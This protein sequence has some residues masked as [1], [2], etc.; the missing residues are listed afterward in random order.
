M[1]LLIN[2][3][4]VICIVLLSKT[5][6]AS[7]VST[8]DEL[9]SIYDTERCNQCHDDIA[10]DWMKSSH[11]KSV[12]SPNVLSSIKD[13]IN[14]YTDIKK[15]TL[16]R[17]CLSC[18]APQIKDA[19]NELVDH[20]AELIIIA[21]SGDDITKSTAAKQELSGLSINCRICHMMKGMPESRTELSIIYGPGWD[22]HEHSHLEDYGFDTIKSE[23]LMSS[24]FCK[25]C[26]FIPI[27]NKPE[28]TILNVLDLHKNHDNKF[29]LDNGNDT[30]H[31]CHMKSNH[32][33]HSH[34]TIK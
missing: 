8:I 16:I 32:S 11:S 33:F 12:I 25:S 3:L 20:I 22:E 9:V 17:I 15:R 18:H 30:C 5:I 14:K 23:Y 29:N 19:S 4:F 21:S 13:N 24:D 7:S 10:P 28:V 34:E 2:I 31:D 26:H 6:L 1:R 27:S